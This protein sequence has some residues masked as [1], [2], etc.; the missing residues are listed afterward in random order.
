MGTEWSEERKQAASVAY[1]ERS[2]PKRRTP[3]SDRV[4]ITAVHDT[5]EGFKDRWVNDNPGRLDKVKSYG[6][7]HVAVAEVGSPNV[8]GTHAEGGV[9]SR[10]MGKNVRAYLMRQK[11]DDFKSD[12]AEKQRSIDDTEDGMRKDIKSYDS[13]DGSYG[14][15]KIE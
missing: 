10:E 5:P 6:Y 4:D 2:K 12:Q 14:T 15:V 11:L 8:D 7:E 3:A 13:V 9:V 1:K